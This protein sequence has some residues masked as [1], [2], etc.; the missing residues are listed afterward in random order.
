VEGLILKILAT[1][2]AIKTMFDYTLT[3]GEISQRLNQRGISGPGR[4]DFGIKGAAK[5]K[6]DSDV[7]VI[8][9]TKKLLVNLRVQLDPVSEK[10]KSILKEVHRFSH[11]LR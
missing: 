4:T 7:D 2:L 9:M 6:L 1:F 8:T 5:A 11:E 3:N 10:V